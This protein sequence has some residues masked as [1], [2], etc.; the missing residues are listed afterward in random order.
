[1]N[2]QQ[3]VKNF[4]DE[5]ESQFREYTSDEPE[6]A[7]G[8]LLSELQLSGQD[9]EKLHQAVRFLLID[10]YYT[11]LLGLDGCATLGSSQHTF[12]VYDEDG[13]LISECGDIEAEA[14]EQFQNDQSA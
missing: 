2:T 10:T 6:T 13:N 8:K 7:V 5:M 4:R 9:R 14:W 1:M 3:F 12:K 11:V